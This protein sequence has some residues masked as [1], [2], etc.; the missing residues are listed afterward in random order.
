MVIAVFAPGRPPGL[1]LKI[2]HFLF[3]CGLEKA[4]IFPALLM[5]ACIYKIRTFKF[6]FYILF[7]ARILS[8]SYISLIRVNWP[9][10]VMVSHNPRAAMTQTGIFPV[11]AKLSTESNTILLPK[12][13]PSAIFALNS[14]SSS[15]NFSRKPGDNSLIVALRP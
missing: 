11:L 9:R 1:Q 6:I 7:K 4:R 10:P 15:S 12:N 13:W 5:P 14:G 8:T 3:K 2:N